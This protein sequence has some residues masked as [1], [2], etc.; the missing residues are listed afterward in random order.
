MSWNYRITTRE[1][2]GNRTFSISEIYYNDKNKPDGYAEVNPLGK[3]EDLK[4]LKGTY[5]LIKKAF[6]EPIIDLDN[7]P[8]IYKK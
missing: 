5:D 8:K 4:D 6:T 1:L 7:F 3:W 2:D